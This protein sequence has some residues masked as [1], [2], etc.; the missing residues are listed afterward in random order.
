MLPFH[1]DNYILEDDCYTFCPCNT[2]PLSDII[3]ELYSQH[4]VHQP[5]LQ[6][7]C[8][9]RDLYPFHAVNNFTDTTCS[10]IYTFPFF[11]VEYQKLL[12]VCEHS[13]LPVCPLAV[14]AALKLAVYLHRVWLSS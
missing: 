7:K 5:A 12:K 10:Y 2:H 4:Y 9:Q 3:T 11:P 14:V 6:S 8:F 13:R 1:L